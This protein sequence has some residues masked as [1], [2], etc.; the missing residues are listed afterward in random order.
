LR[1][2]GEP[3]DATTRAFFEP[4]FGHDFS[5]VRVHVD[6]TAAESARAVNALAYTVAPHVV[7]GAGRH[8][9][10]TRSGRELL[11]HELTHVVQ[12]KNS[13][14]PTSLRLGSASDPRER[15]AESVAARAMSV[16]APVSLQQASG[17]IQRQADHSVAS[18]SA[19]NQPATEAASA[20]ARPS[21]R[22]VV[23]RRMVPQDDDFPDDLQTPPQVHRM[24]EP[25]L[26]AGDGNHAWH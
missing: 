23:Q 14:D 17:L 16:G 3:L 10:S 13:P 9:P 8:A 22:S 4:R 20:P 24:P 11:A 25:S 1:S 5:K 6:S 19:Q 15:E 26:H 21:S 12:Q 7:F 2:P 18:S